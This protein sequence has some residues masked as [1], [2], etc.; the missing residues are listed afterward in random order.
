MATNRVYENGKYLQFAC[1]YPA[2]PASGDPVLVGGMPGVAE[3][4]EQADGL[5]SVDLGPAVYTLPVTAVGA[6]A[7][8]NRLYATQAS[9]VVISNNPSGVPFGFA[10]GAIAGGQTANINVKVMSHG[11][12]LSGQSGAGALFL[13]AEVTGTGSAQNVAHGLGVVPSKVLVSFT[14]LAAGLAAGADVAE[15]THT[16]T[17]VV[18]T[19]TSGL[20]FKVLAIA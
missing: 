12:A 9:P 18:L 16:T 13:S 1:D 11:G 4:A 10:L 19:V 5:T 15:G 14:E 8:G 6:I 17:N 20:K 2:T 3:T 7:Q